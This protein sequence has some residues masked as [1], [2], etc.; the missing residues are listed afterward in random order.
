M[1]S[2]FRRCFAVL[3]LSAGVAARASEWVLP[4]LTGDLAGNYTPTALVGAP[5]V[6][7]T[8]KLALGPEGLRLVKISVDG[9]G[10][11]V[12][13][14]AQ[15]DAAGEGTWRITEA[16]LDL[17]PWLAGQLTA[18]SATGTG[19]GTVRG[20][21]FSGEFRLRVR[22]L[23]LGEILRIGDPGKKYFQ[24]AKGRAEGTVAFNLRAGEFSR[25]AV[26]LA[27]PAGTT[28]L[29]LFRP[30][31]GLLSGY[32]PGVAKR[33]YTG[34]EAIELGKTPLEASVLRLSYAPIADTNG[35]RAMIYLEGAPQDKKY[36]APLVL[37]VPFRG[38]VE[39][40]L[41]RSLKMFL[42]LGGG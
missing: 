10:T 27:I 26:A 16:S 21:V 37:E 30:S 31:P 24:S 17:K 25:G 13:A 9:P 36:T 32:L 34:V 6:H 23:D 2:W 7:W 19:E 22:D 42:K 20:G 18:G 29:I 39:S 14:E 40:A 8:L 15:L 38:E 33:I 28:G 4:P 3:L 11:H 12:L 41:D 5:T 35:V 1:R